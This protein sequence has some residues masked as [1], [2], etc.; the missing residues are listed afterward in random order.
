MSTLKRSGGCD[1]EQRFFR[2]STS[3]YELVRTALNAT[4]GFP[5]AGTETCIAPADS[6]ASPK[7]EAGNVLLAVDSSWCEWDDV[8]P[9]L[10][11]LLDLGQVEE[12]TRADYQAAVD[13][14]V[15]P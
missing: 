2:S 9:M 15:V 8:A 3:T 1:V 10:S 7:D 4:W 14:I 13:R 6:L 11:Q 5:N 12:V